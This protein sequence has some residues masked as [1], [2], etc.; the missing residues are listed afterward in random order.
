[1]F[2]LIPS[3]CFN[4]GSSHTTLE[5]LLSFVLWVCLI[6]LLLFFFLNR[7]QF[8]H[9]GFWGWGR[10][11]GSVWW[12]LLGVGVHLGCGGHASVGVDLVV[13]LLSARRV[14]VYVHKHV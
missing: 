4:L 8:T 9:T 14:C 12:V 1:M 3:I 10:T 13:L 6:D 5:S 11:S 2:I 7:D